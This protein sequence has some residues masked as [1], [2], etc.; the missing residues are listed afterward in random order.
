M[1]V[2]PKPL[3]PPA[4][5]VHGPGTIMASGASKVFV[6]NMAAAVAGDTC[7]CVPEP[8]NTIQA[9]SSTV[10]FGKQQAARMLDLTTHFSGGQITLGSQNVF[11]GG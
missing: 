7:T 4:V 2:C 3:D 9:G 5:G 10:F 8:G 1:H 6:N 11:I